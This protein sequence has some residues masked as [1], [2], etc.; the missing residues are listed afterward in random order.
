TYM[1]SVPRYEPPYQAAGVLNFTFPHSG[2]T[3]Y[4]RSLN[5]SNATVN[6]HYD[7]D[8]VTY[9]RDIFAS[10]P[11]NRV[12]VI[13]LT[14]SQPGKIAFSCNLTTLQTATSNTVVGNDLVMHAKV[15]AATRT[16]YYVTGLTNKVQ[17]DVRVRLIANGGTVSSSSGTLSVTNADDV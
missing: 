9:N 2:L 7:Y 14:A 4:M 11:G 17:Y 1:M 5:L 15:S 10:A 8:G 12:I 6:V 3:N 16:E 13:H